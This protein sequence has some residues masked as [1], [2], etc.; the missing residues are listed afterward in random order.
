M[1]YENS[2]S[3]F[4][5]LPLG[6]NFI[7]YPFTF[8]LWMSLPIR[9]TSCRIVGLFLL[10][11]HF[12]YFI[13]LI[14]EEFTEFFHLISN[15]GF[16]FNLNLLIYCML[17]LALLVDFNLMY[18]IFLWASCEHWLDCQN[19][20]VHFCLGRPLFDLWIWRITSMHIAM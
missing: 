5:W 14:I 11:Q 2:Y 18:G 20:L 16:A 12:L 1:K 3:Y 9:H 8:I 7:F 4:L 6:C 10:I 13:C 19:V 17:S 15:I